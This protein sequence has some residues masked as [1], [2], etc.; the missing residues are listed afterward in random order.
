VRLRVH[1]RQIFTIFAVRRTN[2]CSVLP[3]MIFIFDWG[4]RTSKDIGPLAAQ[5]L[6]SD[7]RSDAEFLMLT[8]E[9][10]WFRLFFIPTIPTARHFFLRNPDTDELMPITKDFAERYKPLALLNARAASGDIGEESYEAER[11]AYFESY[12]R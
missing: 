2:Y 8:L 1:L 7:K 9:T 11:R 4:Y 6:P 3:F 5:D 10:E 12:A